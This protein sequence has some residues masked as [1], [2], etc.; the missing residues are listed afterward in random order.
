M[1]MNLLINST[2][3]ETRG[4]R[5]QSGIY[6]PSSTGFIDDLILTTSSHIQA[7]WMLTALTVVATWARMKFKPAKSRSLVIKKG[8]TTER[9]KLHI[10]NEE[11]PYIVPGQV[12]R[13]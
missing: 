12:C 10:Q 13:C 11:I 9:F 4:P 3:R 6:L 5:T 1:G 2:K 8:M 7:R